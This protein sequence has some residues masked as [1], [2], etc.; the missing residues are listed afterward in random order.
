[1]QW[2]NQAAKNLDL[3]YSYSRAD[4]GTGGRAHTQN[5]EIKYRTRKSFQGCRSDSSGRAPANKGKAL[6]SNHSTTTKKTKK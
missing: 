5:R 1:M 2:K 6:S 4:C 3:F